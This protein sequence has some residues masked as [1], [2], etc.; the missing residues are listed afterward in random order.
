MVYFPGNEAVLANSEQK[1]GIHSYLK[2]KK[3]LWECTLRCRSCGLIV[4]A[5]E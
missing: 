1:N 3:T 5:E 4:N 2:M